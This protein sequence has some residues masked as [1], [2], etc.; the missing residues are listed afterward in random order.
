MAHLVLPNGKGH[1]WKPDTP[2]PVNDKLMRSARPR[3]A[4]NAPVYLDR[5]CIPP[6]RDQ[7]DLGSCTGFGTTGALMYKLRRQGRD[8]QLSPLFAYYQARVI[9]ASVTE[10]AGAEIRDAIKG[11]AH[12]GVALEK[13]WP[14]KP[15]KFA[16]TPTRTAVRSALAHQAVHYYRCLS[17]DD[18]LQALAN[19]MPVVFGFTCYSSLNQA[20]SN[21]GHVPIPARGEKVEGGHCIWAYGGDTVHSE[22]EC[23]NSWGDWTPDGRLFIPFEFIERGMA[24]DAWA[25]DHEQ[26]GGGD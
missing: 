22:F 24:D 11:A 12:E 26:R 19:D 14:Y 15:A 18:V 1:G 8:A 10:D 6:V 16:K 25:V 9:E 4:V 20:A 3:V 5:A 17:V 7:G 2:D 21:G 13:C 23:Q